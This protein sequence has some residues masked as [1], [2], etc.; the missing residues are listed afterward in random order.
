MTCTEHNGTTE[1]VAEGMYYWIVCPAQMPPETALCKVKTEALETYNMR[2]FEN[3]TPKRSE[4][5]TVYDVMR[6]LR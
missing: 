1:C 2:I 4:K 5:D 6:L 3:P